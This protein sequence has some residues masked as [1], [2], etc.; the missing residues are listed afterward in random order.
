LLPQ[1]DFRH[2]LPHSGADPRYGDAYSNLMSIVQSSAIEQLIPEQVMNKQ[3]A[4]FLS[5]Q[6]KQNF[7][8]ERLLCP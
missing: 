1:G 3:K 5:G 7:F 8:W 6:R 2:R 4:T